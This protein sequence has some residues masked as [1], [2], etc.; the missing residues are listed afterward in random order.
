MA[1][2]TWRNVAAPDFSASM[3]GMRDAAAQFNNAFTGLDQTIG[4]VDANI[5]ER[6]NNRL[7]AELAT[8]N[9]SEN[10]QAQIKDLL[11]NTNVGRLSADTL[12]VVA[13]TPDRL[14]KRDE[15]RFDLTT[16]RYNQGR[17]EDR[18]TGFD[19]T[20]GL[21]REY[22][23]AIQN[24]DV[25]R[26]QAIA[27]QLAQ[28]SLKAGDLTSVLS[29]GNDLYSGALG[30]H[31]RTHD[32][33]RSRMFEGVADTVAQHMP[34]IQKLGTKQDAIGY[35]NSLDVDPRAKMA[36]LNEVGAPGLVDLDGGG[37]PGSGLDFSGGGAGDSALR[38]M[39]YEAAGRGFKAVPANITTLGQ[40]SD[41][42][43]G[44]NRQGIKSSAMGVYQI[45]GDTLR[46]YAPDVLGSDWR[47]Q[48]L[49][50]E[51]QDKIAKAI[52]EDNKHSAAAL[53]K[54]WVSLSQAEAEQ[55]IRQPWEKARQVIAQKESGGN[56]AAMDPRAQNLVREA[57]R[58][59]AE[60]AFNEVSSNPV[61][62]GYFDNIGK[63]RSELEVARSLTTGSEDSPAVFVGAKPAIIEKRLREIRTMARD[64]ATK[65]G[66]S[67]FVLNADQAAAVLM[68]S[69]KARGGFDR[70]LNSGGLDFRDNEVDDSRFMDKQAVENRL[71]DLING[72]AEQA[73]LA[74]ADIEYGQGSADQAFAAKER[75]ANVVA[76]LEGR[77]RT[78]MVSPAVLQREREKLAA[79]ETVWQNADAGRDGGQVRSYGGNGSRGGGD[80][81]PAGKPSK[82]KGAPPKGAPRR[83]APAAQSGA[84]PYSR[85]LGSVADFGRWL[86]TPGTPSRAPVRPQALPSDQARARMEELLRRGG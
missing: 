78:G 84:A 4:K 7:L 62:K 2:P 56:P 37:G 64:L 15:T 82:G 21:R 86:I 52:F 42:Q 81:P 65:A 83:Q 22:A 47:N 1:P 6:V 58:T 61:I 13:G 69:L 9:D 46:R 31:I 38:V 23:V 16:K 14:L 18:N 43:K 24:R 33:D 66:K 50:F 76:Q 53:R 77:A 30:N 57:G 49:D 3:M 85:A 60:Q 68:D 63:G 74:Q 67:D 8:M 44:L 45:V 40:L 35:I 29:G 79:L 59:G 17:I 72:G 36:L 41:W 73:R 39:N 75:Q 54:Q 32:F 48:S 28:S 80:A 10:A 12:G 26:A 19:D 71:L 70:F 34:T 27:A 55:L 20:E 11:A 25:E 5:S 51:A